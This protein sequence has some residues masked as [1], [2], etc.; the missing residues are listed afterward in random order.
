MKDAWSS[1]EEECIH[2][3]GFA[4][5]SEALRTSPTIEKLPARYV[6]TIDWM[7]MR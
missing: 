1:V 5:I 6:K 7:R 3:N 2:G 4:N